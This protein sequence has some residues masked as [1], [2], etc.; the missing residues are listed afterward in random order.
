MSDAKH[1]LKDSEYLKDALNYRKMVV[2]DLNDPVILTKIKYYLNRMIVLYNSMPNSCGRDYNRRL[3]LFHHIELK[4]NS[5]RL[6]YWYFDK[7]K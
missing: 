5:Y 3:K 6:K 2:I 4:L 7:L 1:R